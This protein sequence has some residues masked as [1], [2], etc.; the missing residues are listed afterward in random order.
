MK[1]NIIFE[2]Q[3]TF[4]NTL[5]IDHE[6]SPLM[7]R[8]QRNLEFQIALGE[9][10]NETKCSSYLLDSSKTID[11]DA[12][13]DKYINC[14]SKALIIGIDHNYTKLSKIAINS[15]ECCL[16][17]QFLNLYIDINDLII[18]PSIDHY[19]T[20]LEDLVSLGLELGFSV[21]EILNK[22][23]QKLNTDTE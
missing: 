11:H 2:M 23:S 12:I 6:L 7:L 8:A 22:L 19:E 15:S 3:K 10:A 16:N 18:S 5:K 1:I 14:F 9:L 20:L 21:D 4:N 13:F 17:N